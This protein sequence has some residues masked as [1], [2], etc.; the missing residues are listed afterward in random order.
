MEDKL[1]ILVENE[2]WDDAIGFCIKNENNEYTVMAQKRVVNWCLKNGGSTITIKNVVVELLRANEFRK[3]ESFMEFVDPNTLLAESVAYDWQDG[4]NYALRKG[5]DNFDFAIYR[6]IQSG[7]YNLAEFLKY[8]Q[9][10]HYS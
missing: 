2:R 5:A 7:N 9:S 8:K 6:A 10:K 1:A 3:A 4:I